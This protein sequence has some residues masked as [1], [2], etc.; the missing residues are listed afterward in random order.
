[1]TKLKYVGA[2]GHLDGV[3]ALD[4]TDEMIAVCGVTAEEL[5]ASGLYQIPDAEPAKT[6]EVTNG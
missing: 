5:I 1:M 2:G 3:P 6:N 4:L